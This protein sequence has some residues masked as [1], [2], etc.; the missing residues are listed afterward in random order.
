MN[1]RHA[2]HQIA[3]AHGDVVIPCRGREQT[4]NHHQ[5][6]DGGERH[7]GGASADAGPP[8]RNRRPAAQPAEPDH[9][10][11]NVI[12][13][14]MIAQRQHRREQRQIPR[15]TKQGDARAGAQLPRQ[16]PEQSRGDRRDSHGQHPLRQHER[17][18]EKS[19]ADRPRPIPA[20]RA[21]HGAREVHG[22]AAGRLHRR[23]GVV[24][25]AHTR[26]RRRTSA[27]H[28]AGPIVWAFRAAADMPPRS[29][30]RPR[31]APAR[32][33]PT[34][35]RPTGTS[36]SGARPSPHTAAGSERPAAGRSRTVPGCRRSSS[37]AA[38]CPRR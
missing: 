27:A 20:Q 22:V 11:E 32:R 14:L 13:G 5:R 35:M 16:K 8:A 36:R 4:G 37:P 18:V 3:H 38:R 21:E 31:S 10:K 19:G 28:A 30:G 24:H 6:V 15:Q 25:A 26:P 2:F 17:R 1:A 34:G 33:S 23:H 7:G 12:L 9:R 29:P